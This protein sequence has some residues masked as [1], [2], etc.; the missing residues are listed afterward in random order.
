MRLAARSLDRAVREH[1]LQKAC[2]IVARDCVMIPLVKPEVKMVCRGHLD[3]VGQH[4][5]WIRPD[6]IVVR[7]AEVLLIDQI[8]ST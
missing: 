7:D 5:M 2:R 3:V 1:A 6:H 8:L 4:H